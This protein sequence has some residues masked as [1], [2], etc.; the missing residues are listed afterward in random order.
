M[1]RYIASNGTACPHTKDGAHAPYYGAARWSVGW[2]C[3]WCLTPMMRLAESEV[4]S[5]IPQGEK[6]S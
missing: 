3:W 4:A 2:H 5:S 1:S 6:E